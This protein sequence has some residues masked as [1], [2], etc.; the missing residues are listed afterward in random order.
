MKFIDDLEHDIFSQM[1]LGARTKAFLE[2][3][4]GNLIYNRARDEVRAC[5]YGL[6]DAHA[7]IELLRFRAS[8]AQ[9]VINWIDS[10]INDGDNAAQILMTYREQ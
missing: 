7:D 8:T 3:E 6:L 4:I 5:A 9:N 2:T 10:V 1:E